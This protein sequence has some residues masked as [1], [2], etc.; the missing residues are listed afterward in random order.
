M[1]KFRVLRCLRLAIAVKPSSGH[2]AISTYQVGEH[3][4]LEVDQHSESNGTGKKQFIVAQQW[5]RSLVLALSQY[6]LVWVVQHDV[7]LLAPT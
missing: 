5:T 6:G 4:A 7:V 3:N 1:L 2:V